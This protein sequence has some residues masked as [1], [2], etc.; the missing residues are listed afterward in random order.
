[1]NLQQITSSTVALL[2]A[3]LL[4]LIT[5]TYTGNGGFELA[6]SLLLVVAVLVA[7]RQASNRDGSP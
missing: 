6:G 1:M 4:L 3:A 2:V 5:G 7:L